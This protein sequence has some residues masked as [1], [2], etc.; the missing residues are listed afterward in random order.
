[1]GV[2]IGGI[3]FNID[4]DT[5]NTLVAIQN[6]SVTINNLGTAAG[7]TATEFEKFSKS[8]AGMHAGMQEFMQ[9]SGLEKLKEYAE[10]AT[11]LAARVENLQT[12]LRVVGG[13]AGYSNTQLGLYEEQL[14]SLGITTRGAREALTLMAQANIDLAKSSQI[15]RVAQDA[16]V[17]SGHN[18]SQAFEHI[19]AAIQKHNTWMLRAEGI[20]VNAQ[21]AFVEYARSVGKNAHQL[22]EFEKSQ[23]VLN[24]VLE[25]GAH[26]SGVYETALGDVYKQYTSLDRF[27][28]EAKR[29]IGSVFVGAFEDGVKVLT[30]FYKWIDKL[31]YGWKIG[32]ATLL[33]FMTAATAVV[34]VIKG[35]TAAWS[36]LT[37]VF[38]ASMAHPVIAGFAIVLGG[39]AAAYIALTAA[40]REAAKEQEHELEI[41]KQR[42]QAHVRLRDLVQEVAGFGTQ[43]NRTAAQQRQLN[44]AMAEAIILM[45]KYAK[46][47]RAL[48]EDPAAFAAFILEKNKDLQASEE[49]RIQQLMRERE[50]LKKN[51]IAKR[52]EHNWINTSAKDAE[53]RFEEQVKKPAPNILGFEPEDILKA[54]QID[55]EVDQMNKARGEK[56]TQFVTAQKRTFDEN[57]S[58]ILEG[59]RRF[60]EERA[61]LWNDAGLKIFKQFKED[62]QLTAGSVFS[63]QNLTNYLIAERKRREDAIEQETE[64]ERKKHA[65]DAKAL[66][67]VEATKTAKLAALE[68]TIQEF[69]REGTAKLEEVTKAR[70]EIMEIFLRRLDDLKQRNSALQRDIWIDSIG[71]NKE[72]ERLVNER[73][74]ILQDT[75]EAEQNFRNEEKELFKKMQDARK[76]MNT[77]GADPAFRQQA[78]ERLRSAEELY[79]RLK[80]VYTADKEHRVLMEQ[81]K[82]AQIARLQADATKDLIDKANALNQRQERLIFEL[83]EKQVEAAKQRKEVERDIAEFIETRVYHRIAEGGKFL[84]EDTIK[85]LQIAGRELKNLQADEKNVGANKGRI[86]FLKQQIMLLQRGA[87]EIKKMGPGGVPGIEAAF[88]QFKELEG[89]LLKVNDPAQAKMLGE[90][91]FATMDQ[92]R[93]KFGGRLRPDAA[94]MRF[95][96]A[97][98]KEFT[99]RL[100]ATWKERQKQLAEEEAKWQEAIKLQQQQLELVRQQIVAHNRVA[101]A[102]ERTVEAYERL[103]FIKKKVDAPKG[104]IIG[105]PGAPPLPLPGQ[106]PQPQ[107]LPGQGPF[108]RAPG[109][110][111]P[112][113]NM[114]PDAGRPVPP[115]GDPNRMKR[116]ADA[117]AQMQREKDAK[118]LE[119]VKAVVDMVKDLAGGFQDAGKAAKDALFDADAVA[120]KVRG[121]RIDFM[122]ALRNKGLI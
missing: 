2:S 118:A 41:A 17:I 73:A 11:L 51:F 102:L 22:S 121:L 4:A 1:M 116:V 19:V 5:A 105:V 32:A 66:L 77:P 36:A 34:G 98:M 14:K 94:K 119:G 80:Q 112:G 99:D 47:L 46:E 27:A 39:I 84:W 57:H 58:L 111:P 101:D 79:D 55:A 23:V 20:M 31:D 18:S 44:N 75:A 54:R 59:L 71:G 49:K 78:A 86:D 92:L 6:L 114:L 62:K 70:V 48:R 103:G 122:N 68:F 42:G 15:A 72:L 24:K 43:A 37:I 52:D 85:R 74:K 33:T 64:K 81:Q 82:N 89:R 60:Q 61:K 3:Q 83:H 113:A 87:A 67:E 91:W 110:G 106:Q 93:K 8:I 65:G 7:T 56:D 63:E 115:I 97:K 104:P 100:N 90:E 12:V 16:A 38:T 21:S 29:S 26:I 30:D 40:A 117:L 95:L 109:G 120:K 53:K 96:D 88:Q 13:Q 69:R 45:P 25:R 76:D 108:A 107:G 50:E 9:L 10:E 28:E 35:L